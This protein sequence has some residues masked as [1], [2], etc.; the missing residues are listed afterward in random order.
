VEN[1]FHVNSLYHQKRFE[2]SDKKVVFL[3]IRLVFDEVPCLDLFWAMYRGCTGGRVNVL[4]VTTDG[5]KPCEWGFTSPGEGLIRI[6]VPFH[7]TYLFF[8]SGEN[9][10]GVFL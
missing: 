5:E 9:N 4:F 6:S 10:Y 7:G 1:I 2:R 8:E 3:A